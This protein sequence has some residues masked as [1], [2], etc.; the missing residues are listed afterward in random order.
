MI[1]DKIHDVQIKLTAKMERKIRTETKRKIKALK[2]KASHPYRTTLERLIIAQQEM[3]L[4]IPTLV[5][6]STSIS[7]LTFNTH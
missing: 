7:K 5:F 4:G 3:Q 2:I 6:P 1:S